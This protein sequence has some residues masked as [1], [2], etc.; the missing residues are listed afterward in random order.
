MSLIHGIM[1]ARMP[2]V[3]PS[4]ASEGSAAP[5]PEAMTLIGFERILRARR[6]EP[7]ARRLERGEITLIEA[8][9]PNTELNQE[10]RALLG[11]RVRGTRVFWGG[12]IAHRE[13]DPVEVLGVP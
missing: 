9:K 3:T 10:S 1:P 13:T 6:G 7:A 11:G 5:P 8:N 12:L 4:E 2:R